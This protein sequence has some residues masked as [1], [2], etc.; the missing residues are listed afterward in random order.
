L[1]NKQYIVFLGTP[2]PHKGLDDIIEA[3]R[4]L[5]RKDL[6]LLVVGGDPELFWIRRYAEH[7]RQIGGEWVEIRG[8]CP[9]S[10]V[11]RYLSV[12][13]L[14]V[15]PQRQTLQ[16]MGQVPAKI[17]DAMAMAKPTISTTVSEIPEILE[18]CGWLVEPEDSAALAECIDWVLSHPDEANAMGQ[19]ARSRCVERY[20]WNA[21]ET[22]LANIFDSFK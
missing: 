13:S 2:A 16:S 21:I 12:A 11:P 8:Y 14:V 3:L 20:S 22:T 19:K 7:L 4:L 9:V 18:G 1:T 10:D 5:N 15:L 6:R 17:F